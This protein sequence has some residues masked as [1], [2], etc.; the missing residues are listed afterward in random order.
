MIKQVAQVLD[1][2]TSI[3]FHNKF[4]GNLFS[5]ENGVVFSTD[6]VLILVMKEVAHVICTRHSL[7]P[8][9]HL[10]VQICIRNMSRTSVEHL[11]R[12]SEEPIKVYFLIWDVRNARK[13]NALQNLCFALRQTDFSRLRPK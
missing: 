5:S 10:N 9:I 8:A 2:C 13:L 12:E 4:D 7:P 1:V 3:I 6:S 11:S